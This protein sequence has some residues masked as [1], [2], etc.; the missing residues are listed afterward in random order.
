MDKKIFNAKYELFKRKAYIIIYGTNTPLGKLFDLVLLAL[1]VIS[2]IMVMLETV[3]GVNE[4]LHGV[5]V[6][7]E[8]VITVSSHGICLRIITNKKTLSLYFQP[9]WYY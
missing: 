8:W 1:I 9:L 6:F 4:H 5:L 3:Q 2:V 7:M